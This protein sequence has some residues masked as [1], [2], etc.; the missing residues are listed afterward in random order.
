[1]QENLDILPQG[2]ADTYEEYL[3]GIKA[4]MN[5]MIEEAQDITNQIDQHDEN[6]F[7]KNIQEV[8]KMLANNINGISNAILD[9]TETLLK[10]LEEK[11]SVI[12]SSAQDGYIEQIRK[13]VGGLADIEE[14]RECELVKG[15]SSFSNEDKEELQ[16]NLRDWINEYQEQ[17]QIVKEE[18]E[19]LNMENAQNELSGVYLG[20]ADL[21]DSSLLEVS[22]LIEEVGTHLNKLE[23][24]YTARKSKME[25]QAKD[26]FENALA[27]IKSEMQDVFGAFTGIDF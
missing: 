8:V 11:N 10:E 18:A 7:T 25:N 2:A 4:S 26:D 3:S 12:G 27:D 17:I 20:I 9:I 19:E 13:A 24:N 22:N 21:L 14:Y 16:R 15:G 23:E 6:N 5:Q 1:M